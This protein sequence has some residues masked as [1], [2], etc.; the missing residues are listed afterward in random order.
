MGRP[1]GFFMRGQLSGRPCRHCPVK[2]HLIATHTHPHASWPRRPPMDQPA[3]PRTPFLTFCSLHC[4]CLSLHRD[5]RFLR[6]PF[7]PAMYT[8]RTTPRRPPPPALPTFS[9][10]SSCRY[11]WNKYN[12]THYDGD[13]PPPKTVQGYKFN[14][15]YPE[16]IDKQKAPTYKVERDPASPDGER[17][18]GYCCGGIRG[19]YLSSTRAKNPHTIWRGTPPRQTERARGTAAGVLLRRYCCSLESLAPRIPNA[20]VSTSIHRDSALWS[21]RGSPLAGLSYY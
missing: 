21:N 14:I 18:R 19:Q 15:F 3:S 12:Q 13:N 8:Y 4:P 16:L 6:R 1:A 2:P 5:T 20:A 17:A 9:S 10:P 11:E 7:H